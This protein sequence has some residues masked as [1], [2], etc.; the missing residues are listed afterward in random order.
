M[1]IQT[2][3]INYADAGATLYGY[4]AWDD[5]ATAS[6][7]GVLVC[8]DGLG[9]GG[10]FERGRAEALAEMGYVG[11]ALDVYGDKQR[12]TNAE[13]AYQLMS[14]FTTDRAMLRQRLRAAITTLVEL[15]TV[16]NTQLAAMGYCFGGLCALE[17]ARANFSTDEWQVKGVASFHGSLSAG[18]GMAADKL[19]S[20]VLA[21][22]G[23]DDP[24]VPQRELQAFTEEMTN[25]N[26]DWQLIAYGG[27]M[28]SFTNPLAN[29]P[30]Q[31]IQYNAAVEQRSWQALTHFLAELFA[32]Q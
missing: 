9:G 20:K 25:A 32:A 1:A 31:G 19:N 7:P 3:S 10:K 13:Q 6:R 2:Q 26:A 23:W 30:E 17:I 28:H 12:A 21:M 27:A 29:A 11:F 22:H 8:H 14:P 16:D 18:K 15:P 24:I 5:N 4:L